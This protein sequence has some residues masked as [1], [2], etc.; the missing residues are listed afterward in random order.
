M[1][2]GR[3]LEEEGEVGEGRIVPHDVVHARVLGAAHLV[4]ARLR[5]RLR[6]QGEGYGLGLARVLGAAHIGE[7]ER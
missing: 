2:E 7:A 6:G 5:L 4:R 1:G 3:V